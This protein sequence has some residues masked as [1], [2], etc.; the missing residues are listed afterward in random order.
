MSKRPYLSKSVYQLEELFEANEDNKQ[1]IESLLGEL[2]HRSVPRALK[3]KHRVVA[4]SQLAKPLTKTILRKDNAVSQLTKS[5]EPK[6][7]A[8]LDES[9]PIPFE[10]SASTISTSTRPTIPKPPITNETEN[11]LRAWTA[12]EVLAPQGFRRESDLVGSDHARIAKLDNGQLPWQRG[13]KSRPKKRLY[14]ELLLG[15]INL[16][17]AVEELLKVYAD[18][19]PDIPRVT[20]RSAL[21]SIM[22]DKEGRP[23]DEDTTFAISSFAWGVP[24]A[25]QGDLRKLAD[26]TMA[27]RRLKKILGEQLVQRDEDGEILPL[28]NSHITQLYSLLVRELNLA[29]LDIS[30][31]S[32]AIRRYEFF[33]SKI[34]PEPNLLNSFYLAD[35]AKARNLAETSELPQALKYYLGAAQPDIRTNLLDDQN[36]LR[37]VLQP[38]KTPLGRWPGPGRHPLALLQ[39]AAVNA[40]STNLKETGLLS[41]NGPPGTGKTTLL[42]DVVAA[43]IIER[44]EVMSKYDDPAKAFS[45]TSQSVQRSGAKITLHRLDDRLKGFEMVVA[46][47]NNKAV[48]NVSA[49]LPSSEAIAS[50]AD[51]LRYFPSISTHVLGRDGWGLIAAVLGNA[52]NRFLFSQSFWR[53]E[54]HGLSTYL[55]HASGS[56]QFV[57]EQGDDGLTVKRFRAVVESE[58]PPASRADAMKRWKVARGNFLEEIAEASRTRMKLQ[59]M[60]ETLVRVLELI[61][62]ISDMVRQV[63]ILEQAIND[64]NTVFSK[65]DASLVHAREKSNDSSSRLLSHK[66]IRPSIFARIFRTQKAKQWK[67][68][69]QALEHLAGGQLKLEKICEST[70]SQSQQHLRIRQ[71]E[72]IQLQANLERA[73]IEHTQLEDSVEREK[74]A[75]NCRRLD[76]I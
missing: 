38:S 31:P 18:K 69:L 12:L 29:N 68:E 61:D 65:A 10:N 17:P 70:Y 4:A 16:G 40:T 52:S 42:R 58:N 5:I 39:Q 46:S 36:G 51:E 53:D 3:L 28:E 59:I 71:N 60:H 74:A 49:E 63:P 72:L 8:P 22:L 24:I 41:V 11:I 21:A 30:P 67:R 54:E 66:E 56:P 20:R 23:L 27:E 15:T 45:P 7:P 32:F 14:Y 13:E 73:Q 34:P 35:L 43:R 47:S 64:A 9:A 6:Q 48:E 62:Q 2:Q 26:W 44:A 50:D 57:T 37:D 19:R 1:I 75:L 33:A 55:N 76:L 25:L